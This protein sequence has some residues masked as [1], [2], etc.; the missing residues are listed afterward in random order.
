[1]SLHVAGLLPPA[2][3]AP[4]CEAVLL[5]RPGVRRSSTGRAREGA[6][7]PARCPEPG[8]WLRTAE[9]VPTAALSPA[10]PPVLGRAACATGGWLHKTVPKVG[11]KLCGG[12]CR[13]RRWRCRRPPLVLSP[14]PNP[15]RRWAL[16][17]SV[18]KGWR[19]RLPGAV[20]SRIA[21][22]P[23]PGRLSASTPRLHASL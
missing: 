19:R 5:S 13:C 22:C 6:T 23:P 15:R 16:S 18:W 21:C 9:L 20:A 4:A 2:R 17:C 11:S 8:G 14:P 12:W 10:A 3:R 7:L 1:L